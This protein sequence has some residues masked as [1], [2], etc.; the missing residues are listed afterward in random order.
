[1]SRDPDALAAA[2]TR[3]LVGVT[4]VTVWD[5]PGYVKMAFLWPHHADR[6]WVTWMSNAEGDRVVLECRVDNVG[7][8]ELVMATCAALN[9]QEDGV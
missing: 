7:G 1:M 6:V 8:R 3:A 5:D 4:A 9:A 2:V